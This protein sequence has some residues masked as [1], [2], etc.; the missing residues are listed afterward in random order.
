MHRI[1]TI[2]F[3]KSWFTTKYNALYSFDS[4]KSVIKSIV[5]VEN[6]YA[7]GSA[8]IGAREGANRCI[9]TFIY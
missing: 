2:V 6:G 8:L 1:K 9:L 3:V 5:T 4:S 7:W